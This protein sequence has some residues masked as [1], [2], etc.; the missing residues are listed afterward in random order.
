M[1]N[2]KPEDFFS[3]WSLKPL[4]LLALLGAVLSINSINLF[5]LEP[6]D[7]LPD[8]SLYELE[9]ELP[10]LEGK[11]VMIDAWASWCA[12]CKASFPAYAKLQ[13]EWADQGFVILGV[14]VDHNA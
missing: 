2:I 1:P 10:D 7:G 11:V 3:M 9:G 6:G 14:S 5:A 4:R 12:P 13:Q 8:W